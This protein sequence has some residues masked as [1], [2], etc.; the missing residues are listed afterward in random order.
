[1]AAKGPHVF[2][3]E[4][5]R[6]G[7]LLDNQLHL[8]R[9]KRAINGLPLMN[10]AKE[11]RD[12]RP[13]PREPRFNQVGRA[14]RAECDPFHAER[15]GLAAAD[16]HP[17]RQINV[18]VPRWVG[19]RQEPVGLADG[20]QAPTDACRREEV[21]LILEE[22]A[23]RRGAGGQ[24]SAVVPP[25]ASTISASRSLPIISSGVCFLNGIRAPSVSKIT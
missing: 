18:L 2:R 1:V 4:P 22:G 12:V 6:R 3:R 24:P 8:G 21:G 25:C 23:H 5:R 13:A 14:L 19:Q 17:Q 7:G 9:A 15:I 16:K 11:R 20:V 10:A